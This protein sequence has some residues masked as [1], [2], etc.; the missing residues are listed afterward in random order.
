MRFNRSLKW[1]ICTYFTAHQTRRY[2]DILRKILEA[3]NNTS[4]RSIGRA[5]SQ[6]TKKDENEIWVRL[7][8]D[9]EKEA[10]PKISEAKKGQMGES[11]RSKGV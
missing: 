3:Y 5:P 6:V 2:L 7:Y 10:R 8:C 11:A 1:R 9:G 4:H